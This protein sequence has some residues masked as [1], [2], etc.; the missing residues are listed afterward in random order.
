MKSVGLNMKNIH[1][2]QVCQIL[3]FAPILNYF[4]VFYSSILFGSLREVEFSILQG[5]H[6]FPIFLE[7]KE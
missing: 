2:G 5:G 1:Q 6:Y 3:R 4:T 7:T